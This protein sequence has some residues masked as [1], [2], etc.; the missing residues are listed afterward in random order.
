MR[1]GAAARSLQAQ[2]ALTPAALP[3]RGTQAHRPANPQM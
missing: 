2:R 1:A 3:H